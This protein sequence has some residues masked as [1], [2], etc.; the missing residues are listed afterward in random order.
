MIDELNRC[1]SSRGALETQGGDLEDVMI[2][3]FRRHVP[4]TNQDIILYSNQ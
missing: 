3:A 4:E 1:S 2:P